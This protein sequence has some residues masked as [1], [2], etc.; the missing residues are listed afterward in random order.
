MHIGGCYSL[1][2]VD[3]K[4]DQCEKLTGQRSNS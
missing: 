1:T 2:A 4:E 3:T